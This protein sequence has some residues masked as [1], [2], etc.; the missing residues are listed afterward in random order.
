MKSERRR[1]D[2]ELKTMAV[3]LCNR[4]KPSKE[5]AEDLR[6]RTNLIHLDKQL[7]NIY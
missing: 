4:S 6:V 5:V 3:T 2:R 1:L 7:K